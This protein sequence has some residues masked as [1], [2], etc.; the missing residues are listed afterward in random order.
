METRKL[1]V[2]SVTRLVEQFP[3]FDGMT[4]AQK[5]A[6]RA[7]VSRYINIAN[8][9]DDKEALGILEMIQDRV[10]T[11]APRSK[12][13]MTVTSLVSEYHESWDGMNPGQRA[14]FKAKATRLRNKLEKRLDQPGVNKID[15]MLSDIAEFESVAEKARLIAMAKAAGLID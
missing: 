13:T 1:N 10:G 11:S 14:A 8:A 2:S 15:K 3:T 5:A 12:S 4:N 6:F 7:R 9:T